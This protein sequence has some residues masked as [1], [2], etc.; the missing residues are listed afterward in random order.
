[1]AFWF[2]AGAAAFLSAYSL[3]VVHSYRPTLA[4]AVWWLLRLGIDGLPGGLAALLMPGGAILGLDPHVQWIMSGA[5]APLLLRQIHFGDPASGGVSVDV[6]DYYD[7]LRLPL[8]NKLDSA[9]ATADALADDRLASRIQARGGTPSGLAVRVLATIRT[10]R[11]L[12]TRTADADYIRDISK[13]AE[14]EYTRL[15]VIIAKARELQLIR[16]VRRYARSPV[17][18]STPSEIESDPD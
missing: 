5:F 13:S 14:D 6:R 18:R 3:L 8:D 12:Q 17:D 16:V 7:R 4:T 10:S 11:A 1:M 15:L 9:S 2:G